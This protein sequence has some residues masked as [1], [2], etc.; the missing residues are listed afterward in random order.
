MRSKRNLG[1]LTVIMVLF[2]AFPLLLSHADHCAAK[3]GDLID[4]LLQL[5]ISD[6]RVESGRYSPPAPLEQYD[7]QL[8]YSRGLHNYDQDMYNEATECFTHALQ[9]LPAHFESRLALAKI[10]LKNDSIVQA[11]LI[12]DSLI[13]EKPNDYRGWLWK[14]EALYDSGLY[15]P[16]IAY[17]DS[18]LVHR[19]GEDVRLSSRKAFAYSKLNNE[20]LAII[21]GKQAV[22]TDSLSPLAWHTLGCIYLNNS[23]DSMAVACYDMV[24]ALENDS[25]HL[26]Y[27]FFNRG[28]AN[29][30]IEH[31]DAAIEDFI[32]SLSYYGESGDTWGELAYSYRL[33]DDYTSALECY[34]SAFKYDN[35]NWYGR[36]Y[37]YYELGNYEK[38]LDCM[39][40]YVK[41]YP[42]SHFALDIIAW[43][44]VKTG[45]YEQGLI[46]FDS[47]L[48]ADTTYYEAI[49]GRAYA[50]GELKRYNSAVATYDRYLSFVPDDPNGWFNRGNELWHARKK[51]SAL[52]SYDSCLVYDN[53]YANAWLNKGR[54]LRELRRYNEAN[55]CLD[56]AR[57][58][59]ADMD[60]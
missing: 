35:I 40:R 27:E 23:S 48:A 60:E 59:G 19:G 3:T 4:G 14:A 47:S 54:L 25:T 46:Y 7:F 18:A 45:A 36:G 10:Q 15:E 20:S 44:L 26:W 11:L 30:Y 16:S 8:N 57:H 34:D 37:C 53:T 24:I 58:Y 9:C 12:C 6:F 39:R 22:A 31:Y 56:S 38:A 42:T 21:C 49:F 50:E 33:I 41:E 5:T 32:A 52:D 29:Q 43:S 13:R 2:I 55:T 17:A 1:V 51:M 28:L